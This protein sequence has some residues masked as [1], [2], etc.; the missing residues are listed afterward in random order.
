M[1]PL[2]VP[3]D[4]A[5]LP[6]IPAQNESLLRNLQLTTRGIRFYVNSLKPSSGLLKK[7]LTYLNLNGEYFKSVK[8][9]IYLSCNILFTKSDATFTWEKRGLLFLESFLDSLI[10]F[11]GL[12]D[13]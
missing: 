10:I 12:L 2:I 5:L 8:H 6:N 4:L 1:N 7:T 3:D 13:F 11:K 9:I